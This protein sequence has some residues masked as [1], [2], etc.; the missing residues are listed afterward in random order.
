ML[1]SGHERLGF[2]LKAE[3]KKTFLAVSSFIIGLELKGN[4]TQDNMLFC[5]QPRLFVSQKAKHC[6]MMFRNLGGCKL[7]SPPISSLCLYW[8]FS[9]TIPQV[10]MN[11]IPTTIS[12]TICVFIALICF[13]LNLQPG[14]CYL[15]AHQY[16]DISIW[17]AL[18]AFCS[19]LIKLAVHW[20]G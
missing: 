18:V 6:Y 13:N 19:L 4:R 15:E 20:I 3:G 2:L 12:W 5:L 14:I 16:S 7:Y 11:P 9:P 8:I 17:L 10:T 1:L